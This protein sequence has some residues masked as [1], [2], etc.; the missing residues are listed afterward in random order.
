MPI[1]KLEFSLPD[2]E[3]DFKLA[4]RGSE[5]F[6]VLFDIENVLREVRKYDKKP[7]DAIKEIEEIIK[8][9]PM[10]DIS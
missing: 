3:D 7:E 8:D 1:A 10:E 9:A 5:Y 6:S 2:E 4:Q